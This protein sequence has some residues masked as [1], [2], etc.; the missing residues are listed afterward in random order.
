MIV[1]SLFDGMSC[2]QIAF[3]ELGIKPEKYYSSEID[4]FAI[5]QT[6]LNFPDTIQLGSV[7]EWRTWDIDWSKVDLIG[8]GSDTQIYRMCGNGWTVEVIKHI[9][10]QG[11][12][13]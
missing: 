4:K 13:I 6:Q 10:M 5:A 3:K 8:A 11:Y 12:K 9:L 1:V 7:T 2:L